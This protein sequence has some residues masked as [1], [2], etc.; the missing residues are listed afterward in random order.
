MDT[1]TACLTNPYKSFTFNPLIK[2]DTYSFLYFVPQKN[3][4]DKQLFKIQLLDSDN[5]VI[6][7]QFIHVALTADKRDFEDH[8]IKMICDGTQ[9]KIVFTQIDIGTLSKKTAVKVTV[10][11][12]KIKDGDDGGMRIQPYRPTNPVLVLLKT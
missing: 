9:H 3:N 12:V 1:F 4:P 10:A 5:D 2:I 8:A 7:E 11:I 6:E